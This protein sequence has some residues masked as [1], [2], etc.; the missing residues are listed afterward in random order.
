[1]RIDLIEGWLFAYS[2]PSRDYTT[3]E[4]F[5]KYWIKSSPNANSDDYISKENLVPYAA[6]LNGL[7][8]KHNVKTN[9]EV[10][11]CGMDGWHVVSQLSAE[12]FTALRLTGSD[13]DGYEEDIR[14]FLEDYWEFAE[15]TEEE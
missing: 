4:H 13:M 14:D 8:S 2:D 9:F 15:E 1:M 10:K 3:N 7:M 12:D 5:T 6:M 11:F